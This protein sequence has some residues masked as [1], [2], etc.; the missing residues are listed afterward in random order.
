[1]ERQPRQPLRAIDANTPIKPV[2]VAKRVGADTGV[3]HENIAVAGL[4]VDG[5]TARGGRGG[6]GGRGCNDG[7]FVMIFTIIV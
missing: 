4:A 7:E 2:G 6:G 1:M 3:S 5:T